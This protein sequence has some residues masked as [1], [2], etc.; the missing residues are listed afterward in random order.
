MELKE[1]Q[2]RVIRFRDA[3]DWRKF[4]T[5]KN[6]AISIALEA[7]ELLEFF[8]WDEGNVEDNREAISH[9]VADILIYLLIFASE[10]GIDLEKSV[11][12]KLRINEDRYPVD[13]AKGSSK[14]YTEL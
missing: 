10:C 12:E 2:E 5:P 3:R 7:A 1:L 14:K 13:K 8:Q 9:E 6:L 11:L 4:H